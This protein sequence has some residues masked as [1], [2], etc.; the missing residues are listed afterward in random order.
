MA[1]RTHA[2]RLKKTEKVK[3]K[4]DPTSWFLFAIVPRNKSEVSETA[5]LCC[6]FVFF[7][8]SILQFIETWSLGVWHSCASD[9]HWAM[10]LINHLTYYTVKWN[11]YE[12]F[13]KVLV[14][15]TWITGSFSGW[16]GG[17]GA[18][19]LSPKCSSRTHFVPIC[20]VVSVSAPC[21]GGA[22]R[23][24]SVREPLRRVQQQ[25]QWRLQG[26]QPHAHGTTRTAAAAQWSLRQGGQ[27][28]PPGPPGIQWHHRP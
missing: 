5:F 26:R 8:F 11:H 12:L 16:R 17:G 20:S 2:V 24:P 9:A 23:P 27:A 19:H 4:I 7:I 28:S 14:D 6:C 22:P 21:G 18:S 1:V 10:L 25:L 13:S 15:V 3:W